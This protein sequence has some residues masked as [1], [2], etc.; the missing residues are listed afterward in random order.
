MSHPITFNDQPTNLEGRCS[1]A[2]FVENHLRKD[3]TFALMLNKH[4]VPRSQY[5]TT[6]L[7]E[8]DHLDTLLP[9]QGG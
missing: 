5:A 6:Y 9:M 8:G 3:D 1:L 4:F 7:E 2:Q